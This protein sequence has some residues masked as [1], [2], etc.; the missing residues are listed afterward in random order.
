MQKNTAYQSGI[1]TPRV[2]V[3]FAL[4]SAG[5]LLGMFSLAATP[6]VETPRAS[7]NVPPDPANFLS[8]S[9]SNANRLPPGVPLPPFGLDAPPGRKP[10]RPGTASGA[11]SLGNPVFANPQPAPLSVPQPAASESMPLASAAAAARWSIVTSPNI[12]DTQ[13]RNNTL[14]AVTCVSASDCWAVGDYFTANSEI[15][16][17][18]TLIEHWDGT[19]WAIVTSPNTSTTASNILSGVTC[20][21]ASDCWAVG[22]SYDGPNGSYHTLILRWNGFSW[23]IVTSPNKFGSERSILSGVTCVSASACWAVGYYNPA[24]ISIY[25]TLIE[26]WDGT[27]WAIVSSPNSDSLDPPGPQSNFLMGVT[28]VSPSDCTAVGDYYDTNMVFT[29]AEQTLIEHYDGTSWSIVTSPNTGTLLAPQYNYLFG[30]T[31]VS[32]TNCWAVGYYFPGGPVHTLTEQYNGVLWTI[33]TSPNT[34]PTQDNL[35]YGVTCVSATDCWAVGNFRT[36]SGIETLI[37]QYNGSSW[38]IVGSQTTSVSYLYGVTCAS[39]S[40]CWAV[41]TYHN[42]SA[43]QTLTEHYAP[44]TPTS[45]VSRKTHGTAGIFDVNLPII[46]TPGIE[47][48]SGGASGDYQV[49]VTFPN[50]VTFNS[51]AVTA[52]TGTVSSTTGSGT[53]A[54][55]LNL[56]GV[57]NAQTITL[58]LSGVN[59]GTNTGDIGIHMAVLVGDTSGDGVVNSADITQ[60]RRQSGNVADSSNFR[61]DVTLDGVINSADITLVRRQ[62]GTALPP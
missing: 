60:T 29:N 30:V 9:G 23:A 20:V 55:T 27:S 3:A 36:S 37:E 48:R 18:Q 28:C 44:L 35:L 49:V 42:G 17:W 24:T 14:Y 15:G 40:D 5:V 34:S 2:L 21:S 57:T 47:C 31:C 46:G 61:E 1:F 51:A 10:L 16:N 62:S 41:G 32:A 56:T 12:S 7:T 22:Y 58:T 45:V 53:T 54:V 26:R 39:T 13:D 4:C 19:S 43:F 59:D 8:T 38:S 11:N 33:V 25:Q 6:P 50:A 52:G